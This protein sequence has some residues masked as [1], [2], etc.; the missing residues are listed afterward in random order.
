MNI[1]LT[2]IQ[3]AIGVIVTLVAILGLTAIVA[4]SVASRPVPSATVASAPADVYNND[5]MQQQAHDAFV[6]VMN[7]DYDT[8]LQACSLRAI[9]PQQAQQDFITGMTTGGRMS[10][11]EAFDWWPYFDKEFDQYCP[12]TNY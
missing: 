3:L 6:T 9:D 2:P 8:F 12:T 7:D 5:D 4:N 11:S 10:Y 1:K